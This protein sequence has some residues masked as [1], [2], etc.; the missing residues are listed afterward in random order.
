MGS[1]GLYRGYIEAEIQHLQDTTAGNVNG[2]CW[3]SHMGHAQNCSVFL[4]RTLHLRWTATHLPSGL[5]HR[6]SAAW[7]ARV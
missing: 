2:T 7:G 3:I 5:G 6:A 4:T 1:I